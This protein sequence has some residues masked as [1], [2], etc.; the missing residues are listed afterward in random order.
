MNNFT[1]VIDDL[2]V[3]N[4]ALNVQKRRELATIFR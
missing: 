3:E 2:E 1:A 4:E